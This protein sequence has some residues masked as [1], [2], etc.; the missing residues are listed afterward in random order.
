MKLKID[1]EVIKNRNDCKIHCLTINTGEFASQQL[2]CRLDTLSSDLHTFGIIH[3]HKGISCSSGGL[4]T[5][6]TLSAKI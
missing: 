2:F 6:D 5:L 4:S 3:D 1:N